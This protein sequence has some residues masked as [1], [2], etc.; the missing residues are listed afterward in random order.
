MRMVLKTLALVVGL[1]FAV[2]NV[3][4]DSEKA[5]LDK[6][7]NAVVESLKAKFPKAEMKEA[8]KETTDGKTT[9][10]VS[11]MDG[12]SKVD[13]NLKDDGT[14]TGY[15]KAIEFKD[16]PKV[17]AATATAKYPKLTAK[18]VEMVYSVKDGKDTLEYYEAIY[19]IDGKTVELEILADGKL[20][21]EE[22]KPEEKKPEEKK[23]EVKKDK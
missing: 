5:P 11:I 19:E 20:K 7:P 23:P 9:F 22:K 13:V 12:K 2:G 4:A 6:L 8:S 15:E 17:V 10:E 18:S 3:R 1:S 16:L 14:I 21:P